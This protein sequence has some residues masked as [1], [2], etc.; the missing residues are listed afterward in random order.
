MSAISVPPG[1]EWQSNPLYFDPVDKSYRYY[2]HK[3]AGYAQNVYLYEHRGLPW[4]NHQVC[5]PPP[6][7]KLSS[8]FAG[9]DLVQ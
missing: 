7:P 4:A 1:V 9:V 2:Y 6:F 3:S 5:Y 8:S